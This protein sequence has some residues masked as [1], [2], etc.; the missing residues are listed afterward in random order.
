MKKILSILVFKIMGWKII[1][2]N[3]KIKK[4]IT[5]SAPHTSNW[6]F[7][8]G[9]CFAYMRGIKP[10]YL[11]KSELYFWPLSILIRWNGGI[12]VYRKKGKNTVDQVVDQLNATDEMIL[13][14][15]PEG[16][17]AKVRKWKTGFYH[18]AQKAE[19]PIVLMYMDYAKKEIGFLDVLYP[20]GDLPKD[21]EMI[22]EYYKDKVGKNPELFNP[23]IY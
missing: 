21:M 1:G 10:K 7:L 23:I 4:Y 5:I 13:G 14:I 3:P 18:I 19:V 6:D 8:I 15:A 22:Q 11:I 12:P 2:T 16:T 20:S 17:R 9:R